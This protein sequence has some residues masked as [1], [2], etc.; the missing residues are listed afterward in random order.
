MLAAIF[1]FSLALKLKRPRRGMV[2]KKFLKVRWNI[3]RWR[4]L[5]SGLSSGE[6]Q[7]SQLDLANALV[8]IDRFAPLQA[9]VGEADRPA[10]HAFRVRG[11]RGCPSWYRRHANLCVQN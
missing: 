6:H 7:I 9:R 3:F 5:V 1:H 2:R 8:E 11:R 4:V 10:F